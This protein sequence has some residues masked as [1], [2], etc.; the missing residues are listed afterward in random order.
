MRKFIGVLCS[1]LA[2]AIALVLILFGGEE[3]LEG[4]DEHIH[5]AADP[6]IENVVDATCFAKGSYDE[7]TYCSVPDCKSEINRLSKTVDSLPHRYVNDVCSVCG[8]TQKHSWGLEYTSLGDGS[9]FVSG[10]GNCTDKHISIPPSS[11]LGDTVT[12]IGDGA[13]DSCSG[14]ESVTLPSGVQY[15]EAHAFANCTKLTSIKLPEG[16]QSSRQ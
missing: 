16:V 2:I 12:G 3:D 7:V 11:P 8:R 10:I 5:V 1:I 6:V 15:I 9:C 13:F 4:F 14:I